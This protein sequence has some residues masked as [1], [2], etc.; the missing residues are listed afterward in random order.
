MN[1]DGCSSRCL[2]DIEP[3]I[4]KLS[5]CGDG[6]VDQDEEC[7]D[8]NT[9]AGDGCDDSCK[10]EDGLSPGALA[11]IILGSVAV[12]SVIAVIAYKLLAANRTFDNLAPDSVGASGK[13]L[14]L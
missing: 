1:L 2:Y 12:A 10:N 8:G 13:E 11:G 4:L 14:D 9:E 7:D 6:T 5:A 3:E